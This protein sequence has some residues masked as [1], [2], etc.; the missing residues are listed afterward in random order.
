MCVITITTVKTATPINTVV[1]FPVLNVP[2][3]A[4]YPKNPIAIILRA[5]DKNFIIAINTMIF[6]ILFLKSKFR[7]S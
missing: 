6:S 2:L 3:K 1:E 7:P 5:F 4:E